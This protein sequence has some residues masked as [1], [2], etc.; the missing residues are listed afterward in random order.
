MSKE[1]A[2]K[3]KKGKGEWV[4]RWKSPLMEGEQSETHPFHMDGV[5]AELRSTEANNL[6]DSVVSL[7]QVPRQHSSMRASQTM[8]YNIYRGALK[9]YR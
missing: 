7:I 9:R 2:L 8:A 6:C 1:C 4:S 3:K 5:T